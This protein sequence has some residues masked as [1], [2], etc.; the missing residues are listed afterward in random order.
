MAAGSE[1]C[2]T[3]VEGSLAELAQAVQLPFVAAVSSGDDRGFSGRQCWYPI[4]FLFIVLP[5][6]L[7]TAFA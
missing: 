7:P 2:L 1:T 5:A 6:V 4:L 3:I